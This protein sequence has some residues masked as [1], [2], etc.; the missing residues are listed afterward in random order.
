MNF[1]SEKQAKPISKPTVTEKSLG[2]NFDYENK[3]KAK[4]IPVF[5]DV[6][7][8]SPTD[9]QN[10]KKK[11]SFVFEEDHPQEYEKATLNMISES[12]PI[13]KNG[14]SVKEMESSI[15]NQEKKKESKF[16]KPNIN[17]RAPAVSQKDRLF[18]MK[19]KMEKLNQEKL[20]KI[21]KEKA[22]SKLENADAWNFTAQPKNQVKFN[23]S[24]NSSSDISF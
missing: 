19:Q 9:Q 4:N 18:E 12:S 20:E 5:E 3:D 10:D 2:F 23:D 22:P 21:K 14:T 1:E 15:L 16:I 8:D 11:T 17:F 7:L 6:V 13:H 24:N